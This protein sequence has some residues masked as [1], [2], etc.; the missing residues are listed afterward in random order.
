MKT[1]ILT[2]IMEADER[3]FQGNGFFRLKKA[4]KRELMTGKSGWGE[5]EGGGGG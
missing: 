1:M 3:A 4:E 2:Y 5:G